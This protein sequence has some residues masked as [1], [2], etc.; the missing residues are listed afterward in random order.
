[1][2]AVLVTIEMTVS[3]SKSV[4][5]LTTFTPV[6]MVVVVLKVAVTAVFVAVT[7]FVTRT[8]EVTVS[9]EAGTVFTGVETD[10]MRIVSGG[11]VVVNVIVLIAVLAE[12]VASLVV[13]LTVVRV[14]EPSV[15]VKSALTLS[16]RAKKSK[17]SKII[18]QCE[19]KSSERV[20]GADQKIDE[21]VKTS[22]KP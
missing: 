10:C 16:N 15:V 7:V 18:M 22:L 2:V 12:V 3:V 6:K 20:F 21:K 4:D 9:G 13:H 11:N 14:E 8:V 19:L 17:P 1:M 5:T